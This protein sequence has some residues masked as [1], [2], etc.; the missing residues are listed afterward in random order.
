MEKR[1]QVNTKPEEPITLKVNRNIKRKQ[2]KKEPKIEPI[3]EPPPITDG[4][5]LTV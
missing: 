2:I 4:F 3:K 5:N 1:K